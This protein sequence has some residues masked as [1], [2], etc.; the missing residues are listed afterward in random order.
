MDNNQ[1]SAVAQQPSSPATNQNV[2]GKTPEEIE[3]S[4]LKGNT[5]DRIR[6]LIKERNTFRE[7]AEIRAQVPLQPINYAQPVSPAEQVGSTQM[8]AEQHQAIDNL[9]KFGIITKDDLQ[10][11]QDQLVLDNEYARLE[12]IHDGA[13]GAPRFDRVEVE[14]Y[15]RKTGIYNPEKAYDDMYRDEMFDLRMK[16]GGRKTEEPYSER[17]TGFTAAHTEP[18]TLEGV[19]SRLA[20]PDGKVWWE[21]NRER[22]LPLMGELLGQG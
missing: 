2:Q 6:E 4:R 20:Q 21:K 17:P 8:T 9:R 14:D 18:L 7:Q 16:H 5:Q 19:K 15:M 13:N 1:T 3:W 11:M 10:E 22:I 12:L